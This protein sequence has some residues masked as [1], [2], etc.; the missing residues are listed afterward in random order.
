ME[1]LIIGGRSDGQRIEV[2]LLTQTIEHGG[3]SFDR[4]AFYLEEN[5]GLDIMPIYSLSGM[6]RCSIFRSL[7]SGYRCK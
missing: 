4:H 7:I 6:S 3:E 2:D 1:I 5:E